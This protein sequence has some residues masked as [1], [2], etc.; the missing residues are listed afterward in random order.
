[1]AIDRHLN[2]D[3]PPG[4]KFVLV[5]WGRGWDLGA[6]LSNGSY[7]MPHGGKGWD[8]VTELVEHAKAFVYER[9]VAYP[10]LPPLDDDEN[11]ERV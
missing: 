2:G 1:M 4:A 3:G 5:L 10:L 6:V 8:S 9:E 7:R 11:F